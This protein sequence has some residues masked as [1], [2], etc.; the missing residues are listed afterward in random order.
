M[1]EIPGFI[2]SKAAGASHLRLECEKQKLISKPSKQETRKQVC[3]K[4][5]RWIAYFHVSFPF[6]VFLQFYFR[7]VEKSS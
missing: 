4:K 3:V 1:I 6:E 5:P 7:M 2:K